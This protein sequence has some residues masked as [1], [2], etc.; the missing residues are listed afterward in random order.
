M[1]ADG[2]TFTLHRHVEPQAVVRLPAGADLPSWAAS[3]TLM[4]VTATSEETSV[5]CAAGVVPRKSRH[6]GPFTAFS[7]AGP[8][9]LTLTGVLAG[10][11]APLAGAGISVFT[12][13][14]FDTDWILV[15]AASADAAAEVWAD[16]GHAVE[17]AGPTTGRAP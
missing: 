7:V 10:L 5:V 1:S 15:P 4:S 9:D 11:L 12:V 8:L 13:S 6:A 3:S 16:A 17:A 14:T 2:D